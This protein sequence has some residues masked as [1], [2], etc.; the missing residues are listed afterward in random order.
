MIKVF[1]GKIDELLDETLFNACLKYVGE[2]VSSKISKINNKNSKLRTL[3]G[4]TLLKIALEELNIVYLYDDIIYNEYGKPY[5]AN[6]KD[7]YF[8]IS[9]SKDYFICA[10]SSYEIGCDV[11]KIRN[12]LPK[13]YTKVFH[14]DE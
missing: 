2:R 8:N 13:I 5:F 12:E 7:Y 10:I 1:K 4:W 9:H 3:G 6:S 14:K 11:E